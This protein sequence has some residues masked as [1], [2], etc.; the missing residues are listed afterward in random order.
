VGSRRSRCGWNSGQKNQTAQE[1]L[2]TKIP[3]DNNVKMP[4]ELIEAAS[5]KTNEGCFVLARDKGW[6]ESIATTSKNP[7][8]LK[9]SNGRE[10]ISTFVHRVSSHLDPG[11]DGFARSGCATKAFSNGLVGPYSEGGVSLSAEIVP[12]TKRVDVRN[13]SSP[14]SVH[15]PVR[16]Q[17]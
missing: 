11:S 14:S 8:V 6:A 9:F 17:A 3:F 15:F 7:L 2:V 12:L 16:S 13:E 5:W 1:D 4:L 10:F